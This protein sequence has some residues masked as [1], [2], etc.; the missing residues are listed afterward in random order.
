MWLFCCGWCTSPHSFSLNCC[1]HPKLVTP[2]SCYVYTWRRHSHWRYHPIVLK[3]CPSNFSPSQ[4][5]SCFCD[6]IL[7]T[8]CRNFGW[9]WVISE[10]QPVHRDLRQAQ[11]CPFNSWQE[12]KWAPTILQAFNFLFAFS[13]HSSWNA[14]VKP[15]QEKKKKLI[16]LLQCIIFTIRN[17]FHQS[18]AFFP[19]VISNSSHNSQTYKLLSVSL[20]PLNFSA[21]L[22]FLL[23]AEKQSPC[24][25]VCIERMDCS[26]VK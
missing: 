2:G 21:Y 3:I 24:S 10:E 20:T 19:S 4:I 11:I 6:S 8:K 15:Q 26:T 5:S 25:S 22:F 13:S 12:S 1:V 17:V 9:W 16:I 23:K 18:A 14:I 7:N